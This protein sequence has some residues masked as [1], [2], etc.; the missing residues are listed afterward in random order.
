MKIN[1]KGIILENKK[2]SNN[3]HLLKIH[4]PK[5]SIFSHPGQFAMLKIND[6]T[7][8]LRR[9]FSFAWTNKEKG[10]VNFCIKVVGEGTKYLSRKKPKEVLDII[11]P[12]GNGFPMEK[13]F[14]EFKSFVILGGGMG[15]APLAFLAK[16]CKDLIIE[17]IAFLGAKTKDEII[18]SDVFEETGFKV[19]ISTD[20]GS[21][22]IKSSVLESLV[23]KIDSIKKP[24]ILYACG[25]KNMLKGLKKLNLKDCKIYA[26]LE[27]KMACGI[28][29]CLGCAVKTSGGSYKRVCRDGP[30]FNIN[31]IDFEEESNEK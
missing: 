4:A 16:S 23:S 29:A 13:D 11:G 24:F 7:P 20:D 26:S 18:L 27:E 9:P 22:G 30:I 8:F 5:I 15:A 14:L 17:K 1:E 19:N 2:I 3:I 21:E 31:D 25:P 12:L 6:N 28:G 10:E